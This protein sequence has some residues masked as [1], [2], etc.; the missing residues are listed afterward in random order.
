MNSVEQKNLTLVLFYEAIMNITKIARVFSFE[1]GNVLL[2]GMSG[3][4]RTVLTKM[5][6]F[7]RG[8]RIY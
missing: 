1:Q 7:I 4:G 2:L 5:T 3:S 6:A 8:L